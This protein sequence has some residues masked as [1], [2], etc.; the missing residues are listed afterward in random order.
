M[1]F[2]HTDETMQ[3]TLVPLLGTANATPAS[4]ESSLTIV[5]VD[6]AETAAASCRR[7]FAALQD[8][9]MDGSVRVL[10]MPSVGV[11]MRR[12]DGSRV[13]NALLDLWW[14]RSDPR[15]V[16]GQEVTDGETGSE[17]VGKMLI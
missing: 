10:R 6:R 13:T 11:V 9:E 2:V 3:N 16:Y 4:G 12:P 14:F 15:T 8:V 7:F 17:R 5:V 1:A